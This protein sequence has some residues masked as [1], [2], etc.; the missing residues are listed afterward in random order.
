MSMAGP[1]CRVGCGSR[2]QDLSPTGGGDLTR[3]DLDFLLS[4]TGSEDVPLR[5]RREVM[6]L[7]AAD[8]RG[9]APDLYQLLGVSRAASSAEIA[10]AWRRRAL[11]EHPDRR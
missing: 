9:S 6:V 11:A 5:R 8:H 1:P 3:L 2:S 7:A 4:H 10:R